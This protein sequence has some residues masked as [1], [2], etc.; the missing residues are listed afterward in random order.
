LELRVQCAS[1]L[2]ASQATVYANA[3]P[4]ATIDLG[5]AG[6]GPQDVVRATV[7]RPGRDAWYVVLVDGA[8][9]LWPVRRGVEFRPLAFTNPIWVDVDGN[10]E[11]DPPGNFANALTIAEAREVDAQGIGVR[12]GEWIAVEGCATTDTRFG[13]TSG[14]FY[15]QDATGGLQVREQ[16]GPITEIRR[17]DRVRAAG[18]VSQLLGETVLVDA[19]LEVATPPG[20][21][22]D[23]VDVATG[24]IGW[25]LEALEGSVVRVTGANVVSGSWPQN[26]VEGLVTIDDGSGAVALYVPPDVVVP[27]EAASLSDFRFTALLTQRAFSPPY[28]AGYRLTLRSAVDIEGLVGGALAAPPSVAAFGR[29]RPNPFRTELTIPV[30]PRP[31]EPLPGIVVHNVAGQVV[32][33]L[34]AE[35]SS[36]RAIVWDGRDARG[37]IAGPGVYFV[38]LLGTGEDRTIRV[39]KTGS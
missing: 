33:R 5:P 21:C 38:R 35:S 23:P 20:A 3:E 39:V 19:V 24:G 13:D 36:A 17:G 31:G 10:G 28:Q 6:A 7:H 34:T 29:P 2:R 26:G 11:F 37:G 27:P 8:D 14:L 12:I 9:D 25:A 1:W 16:L 4:V 18:M 32:R 30:F 15:M 22:P